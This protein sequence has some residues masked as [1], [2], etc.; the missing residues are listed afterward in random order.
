MPGDPEKCPLLKVGLM[1]RCDNE[2]K[3]HN[4]NLF[5]VTSRITPVI[6]FRAGEKNAHMCDVDFHDCLFANN[7]CC[8]DRRRSARRERD[9]N[10]R[11]NLWRILL[12]SK[13]Q[14]RF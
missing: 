4:L 1:L 2:K 9:R 13:C 8:P 6:A 5:S 10:T 11:Y 14:Q 7:S 12:S 3:Q